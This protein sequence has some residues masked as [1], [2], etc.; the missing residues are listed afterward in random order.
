M[1]RNYYKWASAPAKLHVLP[2]MTQG[3][4]RI[5]AVWSVFQG[6]LWVANDPKRLQVDS[7]GSDQ[8]VRMHRLICLH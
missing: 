1:S 4:R 3:S 7:E 8:T 2:A 6:T 5:R